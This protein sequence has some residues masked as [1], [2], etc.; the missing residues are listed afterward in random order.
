MRIHKAR[1][2]RGFLVGHAEDGHTGVTAVLAPRGA[3][4][5]VDVRGSAPG[6]RETDLL[7]GCNQV[8]RIHAVTLCGGSAFGLD[9]CG[10]VM[11]Y[12]YE[13]KIGFKTATH[14][15]PI[16]S[17]A[18]L[19]DLL[20]KDVLHYPDRAMGYRACEAAV[21][22]ADAATGSVGAGKGATVGK[23]RGAKNA[24]KGGLG[25]ASLKW[26][27]ATVTAI[28]AVNALGDVYD[29]KTNEVVAGARAK[30]GSFI[31]TERV[32]L[33]ADLSALMGGTNTTI[34]CVLTD[35]RITREEA[36]KIASVAH[37]GLA[38]SIRPIHTLADGDTMFCMSAGRKRV[39]FI[40]L[41]TVA[42]EATR[43]AV[44]DAVA[45]K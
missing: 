16:V 33:D 9:A 12:L 4:A 37:D 27:G 6:T 1:N 17:G 45:K 26:M 14:R 30:D 8:T 32:I 5:G 34:G 40:A 13:N 35:A 43:L 36:N 23:I 2:I 29:E 18:V 15:V 38:R 24:C 10:G 28:V 22:I 31:D 7:R 11:Q 41:C 3:V 21:P 39:N 20:D 19:Y 42:A 25:I 44:L